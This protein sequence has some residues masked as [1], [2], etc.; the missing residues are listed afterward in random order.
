MSYQ[1]VHKLRKETAKIVTIYVLFG[2]AWIYGSDTVL[3]WLVQDPAVMVKIAVVKGS[4]FIFC[5]AILLYFLI[6]RFVQQLAA[7]E[8]VRMESLKNYQAIFNATNEA[9]FIHDAQD[10]RIVDVNDRM[11]EIFGYKR[12]EALTIDIG[13]VSAG[14]PPYSQ[15]EAVEKI[16]GALSDGPQ[17]FEWLTRRKTGEL[18]WSE[19]SL[20]RVTTN[21]YD[22]IIAVVR[23]ISERKQAEMIKTRFLLRQ[24][25]ILDNLPMMAWLKDTDSRLEMINEPYAKTCG[26]TV[27]ACIGKTDLDLF[28][29]DMAKGY[30]ADDRAVCS[31]GLKKQVEEW[32]STPEGIRCHLTYKTPVYDEHGQV[33]GTAGIAQDITEQKQAEEALRESAKKWHAV[34]ERSPVGIMLMDK[35]TIILECNQHF[36]EIFGVERDKYI[37]MNLLQSLPAS[38]VRQYLVDALADGEIHSYTGPYT[39]I[40]TGK[41]LYIN[42]TTEKVAPD[43]IIAIIADIT[44]QR[45]SGLAQEKLQAQL[46]QAQKMESVALLAGGVAH[47]F[48]NM[49]G[50]ILGHTELAMELTDPTLP[51][52]SDL[53]NIHKAANRSALLTRQLLA[54]ARKQNVAP[55]V[56]DLNETVEG[57]LTML[58]RLIGENIRLSWMPA[59][60]LWPVKIDPAQIDQ[61]LANLSVNARDAIAGI[62]EIIVTTG[63]SLLD[64]D[65]CTVHPDVVPGE[66]VRIALQDTGCGMDG[67]T[68]THIFEPFFT[69]KG[70]GEGTG[71]GLASVYGAVLQNKGCIDVQTEPGQGTTVSIYL[72]RYAGDADP[73]HTL[74]TPEF[75]LGGDETILLVEDEVT[76]LQMISTMLK[77]LGYTVLAANSPGH[78]HTLV[79]NHEGSI[80]LLLSDVVMPEMNG[81]ELADRL[82]ALH[83]KLKRLY[84]SGYTVDVIGPHSMLDND[85]DFLQKPFSTKELSAKIRE[86]LDA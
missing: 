29:E 66:Y 41:H 40:L 61:I 84:M 16:R 1:A 19:V 80:D 67:E 48:N 45:E 33:I 68:L 34:F 69:T 86:V 71:L 26:H 17:V 85:V 46:H 60:R 57:M 2:T 52:F 65:Y 3:G 20:T 50:V 79:A 43:L 70:V 6:S 12:D 58:R 55:K 8:S 74:N 81:R 42:I 64:E 62:G 13:Q 14:T 35:Q 24:R 32:I 31:S 38:I 49:L 77:N 36:A 63:N 15:A 59:S 10:G 76:L 27:D 44:S 73:T 21:Y 11:L 30:M 7:A 82:V 54:F 4:L 53:E 75:A 51:V 28:P 78:V 22:R 56:L 83:P 39:S 25:A 9:I 72:P 18:F 5:T 47:D 23:D 37:G